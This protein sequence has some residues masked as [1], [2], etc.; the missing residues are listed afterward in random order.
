[1]LLKQYHLLVLTVSSYSYCRSHLDQPNTGLAAGG[2]QWQRFSY[3]SATPNS[4]AKAM[5]AKYLE[6]VLQKERLLVLTLSSHSHHCRNHPEQIHGTCVSVD[7]QHPRAKVRSTRWQT[8][9]WC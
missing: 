5:S 7:M 1:V 9:R 2:K 3:F 4:S 6:V 8:W